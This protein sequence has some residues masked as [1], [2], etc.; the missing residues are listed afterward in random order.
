MFKK[1]HINVQKDIRS[2]RLV[3]TGKSKKK[4]NHSY[5]EVTCDCGVVKYVK[6]SHFKDGSTKSC[7]CLRSENA[8]SKKSIKN[9]RLY[10]IYYGMISRCNNPKNIGYKNYGGRGIKVSEE[11]TNF[12]KFEKWSMDNGYTDDLS[13]DRIDNDGD[14]SPDNCRWTNKLVQAN[15]TRSNK[16]IE[17][18]GEVRSVAEWSRI[19][20]IDP[21]YVYNRLHQEMSVEDSLDYSDMRMENIVLGLEDIIKNHR[22][23]MR[24]NQEEYGKLY[25]V[26]QHTVSRW[27]N[28]MYPQQ[29]KHFEKLLELVDMQSSEFTYIDGTEIK[30]P[31]SLS[32][33]FKERKDHGS[34]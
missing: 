5:V 3:T 16:Y 31:K 11:W 15:N 30:I 17:V 28:A 20:R 32:Q 19:L 9:R 1:G 26:S 24:L 21:T 7:G 2:Y 34:N 14:Y 6:F 8:S 13:I 10:G 23:E 18:K 27:E 4:N 22:K 25:D 12:K 29:Y 33:F